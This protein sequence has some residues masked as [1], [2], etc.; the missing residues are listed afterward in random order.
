MG[1]LRRATLRLR[2]GRVLCPS[3]G[4]LAGQGEPGRRRDHH[5]RHHRGHRRQRRRG[6]Q[7]QLQ[8]RRVHRRAAA[9]LIGE[10]AFRTGKVPHQRAGVPAGRRAE[11]LRA[12]RVPGR[13]GRALAEGGRRHAE[14]Q[15]GDAAHY[16]VLCGEATERVVGRQARRQGAARGFS[17][18][19]TGHGTIWRGITRGGY[20]HGRFTMWEG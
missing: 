12:A 7:E 1:A 11:R 20:G 4:R 8:G 6:G 2:P 10:H 13:A 17:R 18:G 14:G 9:A 3:A 16:E 15:G 19:R 5:H